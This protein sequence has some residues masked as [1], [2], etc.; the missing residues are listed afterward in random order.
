MNE[1]P[2]TCQELV[3]LVTE[4]LEDALSPADRAWFEAHLGGCSGCRTYLAQ[5]RRTILVAG[6]L[7]EATIPPQARDRLLDIFRTWKH[8]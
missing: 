3:E 5:M 1:A 2:L 8:G 4:Y 6:E 7:T